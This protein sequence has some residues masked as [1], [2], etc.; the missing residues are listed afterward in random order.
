MSKLYGY[1]EK[2]VLGLN[3]F[4]KNNKNDTLSNAFE[5]YATLTGKAKGTVRNMYYAM[6]KKAKVDQSFNKDFLGGC[7]L[8][9]NNPK[10]FS[11][12]EYDSLVKYVINAKKQGK[13]V[14]KATAELAGGDIKLALRYQNKY[15]NAL[16]TDENLKRM[17]TYN[18]ERV[19]AI[20]EVTF[21][22]LKTEINALVNKISEKEKRQNEYLV[23]QL[24]R[25]FQDTAE[26]EQ[27]VPASGP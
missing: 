19:S 18:K 10:Q 5:K 15:R 22:R 13:S 6:V 4:I 2:D 17:M 16:K 23:H 27:G 12:D 24:Y 8:S 20:P 9:V 3:E 21:N 1:D 25:M 14:R 11:K 26:R 7:E